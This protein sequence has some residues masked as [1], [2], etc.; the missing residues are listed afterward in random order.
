MRW[1]IPV[2]LVVTL[3]LAACGGSESSPTTA[4]AGTPTAPV[5][6]RDLLVF[7]AA[8]LTDA[9]TEAG[10]LFEQR[11]PGVTVVLNFANTAALRTQIE[12]GAKADVFASA[13]QRNMDLA[14]QA[15]VIDGQPVTFASNRLA[16]V[17]PVKEPKV[18]S[19]AD[20]AKPGLRLVLVAPQAPIGTYTNQLLD[21]VAKDPAYGADFVRRLRASVVTEAQTVRQ[22]V[23]IVQLG[24][25]DATLVF[26]SDAVG[27]V[28]K[29]VRAVLAPDAFQVPVSYPM[30][31][32]KGA[33]QKALAQEFVQLIASPEG[34]RILA[35]WGFLRP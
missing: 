24:E 15:G 20:L 26:S 33:P 31:V 1:L 6:K 29:D 14:V 35:A 3:A 34:Q 32:V 4:P 21:L 8:S 16:I 2:A 17:T 19:L 23:S 22:A 27:P 25:A 9:F 18:A 30:A 7:A 11:R 5:V 13:D 10:K 12:Q 28:S